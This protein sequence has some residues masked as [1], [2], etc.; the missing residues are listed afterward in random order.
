MALKDIQTTANATDLV[1]KMIT[2]TSKGKLEWN[3]MDVANPG[4]GYIAH[5]D[6]IRVQL[7]PGVLIL[8][9]KQNRILWAIQ[10]DLTSL[11]NA[12]MNKVDGDKETDLT[13]LF[14]QIGG[15]AK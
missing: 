13:W 11:W 8:F 10:G 15:A 12:V 14:D 6:P 5:W 2:A 4:K 1:T 7:E 9:G 3:E